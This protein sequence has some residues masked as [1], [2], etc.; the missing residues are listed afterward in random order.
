MLKM[1][2]VVG[3]FVLGALLMVSAMARGAEVEA[4]WSKMSNGLQGRLSFQKT[5][6][7]N[8]TPYIVAYLELRNVSDVGNV[9][10]VPLKLE[11]IVFEL[12]D[13]KGNVVPPTGGAFDGFVADLGMLRLPYDSVLRFNIASRGAAVAKDQAGLM[14]FGWNYI[15]TFRRGDTHTYSLSAKFSI[16]K[17]KEEA[18]RGSV[19]W[20]GTIEIPGTALPSLER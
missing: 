4:G 20:A 16:A 15:W 17:G 12:R 1:R 9:L 18:S 14:E 3:V 2:W 7:I 19:L 10:E 8:G 13:E 5:E 6:G 11:S